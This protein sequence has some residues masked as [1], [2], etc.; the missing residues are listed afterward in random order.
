MGPFR[1]VDRSEQLD[2]SG[3]ASPSDVLLQRLR[4]GPLLGPVTTDLHG[5]VEQAIIDG[6]DATDELVEDRSSVDPATAR[7]T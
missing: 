1:K 7:G 3:L 4:D 2:D 5:L 6:E